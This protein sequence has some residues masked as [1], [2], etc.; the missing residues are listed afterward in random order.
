MR[1]SRGRG[2]HR[3]RG[4]SWVRLPLG[5]ARVPES[6]AASFRELPAGLVAIHCVTAEPS[7]DEL[8]RRTL[9]GE[10]EAFVALYHRFRQHV[11]R[12]ALAMSGSAS[13]A[14]DVTQDTF[15]ILLA[16]G[17]RYDAAR[18]PLRAY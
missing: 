12:F 4:V 8:L 3:T 13:V 15:V 6:R 1:V 17:H 14:D 5:A 16:E 9:S 11:H 18:G 10:E 7:D 2:W